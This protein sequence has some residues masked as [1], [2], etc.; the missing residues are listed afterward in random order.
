M[1]THQDLFGPKHQGL[2]SDEGFIEYLV[3]DG[4]AWE[5]DSWDGRLIT[6]TRFVTL[7]KIMKVSS[8][9]ELF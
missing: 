7:N 1:V 2:R 3:L 5:G 8:Q 9:I 6:I 4:N